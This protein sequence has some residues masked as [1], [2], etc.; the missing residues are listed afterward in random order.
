MHCVSHTSLEFVVPMFEVFLYCKLVFAAL[1]FCKEI[2]I[3]DSWFVCP[4]PTDMPICGLPVSSCTFCVQTKTYCLKPFISAVSS[5][6]CT[7]S[8]LWSPS[9]HSPS[10]CPIPNMYLPNTLP[11]N[12]YSA[13]YANIYCNVCL[14]E[15]LFW[16]CCLCDKTLDK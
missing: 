1:C 2:L 11:G 7:G 15:F 13:L 14:S 6:I 8:F 5:S 4:L 9:S 16:T 10:P 12:I 3:F